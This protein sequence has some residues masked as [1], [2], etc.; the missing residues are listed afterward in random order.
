MFLHKGTFIGAQPSVLVSAIEKLSLSTKLQKA[1]SVV[2]KVNL[3]AGTVMKPDT[4]VNVSFDL[5]AAVILGIRRINPSTKIFVAES[6]SVGFGF[7]HSKFES[8][9]YLGLENAP[10]FATLTDLTRSHSIRCQLPEGLWLRTFI[11]PKLLTEADFIVS[12]SKMKTHNI[13]RVSGGMKNHFGSIPLHYKNVFHPF[14][15]KVIVDINNAIK[16]DLTIIDGNPGMEGNG[17]VRGQ[18]I[19]YNLTILGDNIVATDSIMT[20]IMGFEPNHVK[21]LR[22]SEDLGLGPIDPAS[23]C[24][25]GGQIDDFARK[26]NYVSFWKQSVMWLSLLVQAFGEMLVE[27]GH[28]VHLLDSITDLARVQNYIQRRFGKKSK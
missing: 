16:T 21:Y 8:L 9:G 3:C 12:L 26:T 28:R 24:I 2:I 10:Y 6:D 23:I 4:G 7:A 13:V 18:A 25:M 1:R 14:L 17:P 19:N 22:L 5:A 27:I 11:L 20:R 15:D